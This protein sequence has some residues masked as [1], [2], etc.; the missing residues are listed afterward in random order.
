MLS[1]G[2]ISQAEFLALKTI[3]AI[4]VKGSQPPNTQSKNRDLDLLHPYKACGNF[5]NTVTEVTTLYLLHA[6]V[7]ESQ[8]C[9]AGTCLEI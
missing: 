2:I 1:P 7:S 4:T 9:K 3:A 5:N 6:V 8:T